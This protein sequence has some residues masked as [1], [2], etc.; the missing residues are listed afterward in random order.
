MIAHRFPPADQRGFTLIETLVA[1][2]I[3]TL[4][5]SVLLAAFAGGVSGSRDAAIRAEAIQLAQ[6]TLEAMGAVDVIKDGE[7]FDRAEGRYHITV[8]IQRY[9]EADTPSPQGTYVAPY[10]VAVEVSWLN[11]GRRQSVSLRTLRIGRQ[12]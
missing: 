10:D 6:S 2:T 7:R 11:G 5:L 12:Q 1:F 4:L 8:S 9:T 3:A